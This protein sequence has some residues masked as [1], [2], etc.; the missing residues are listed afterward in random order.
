MG[1]VR[2]FYCGKTLLITGATGFLG[3]ALVEKVLRTLPEVRRIYL[4]VRGKRLP[5]GSWL[6]AEERMR[7]EFYRS[8]I[9]TTLRRRYQEFTCWCGASG[10]PTVRGS[11]PR[12]G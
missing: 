12:S 4:L 7:Q 3:K 6:S 2:E 11:V 10:C 8:A 1:W 5:D 9:F